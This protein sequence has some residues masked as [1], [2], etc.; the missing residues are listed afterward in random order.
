MIEKLIQWFCGYICGVLTGKQLNRFLNLCSRNGI[1]LWAISCDLER[2]V[3]VHLRLRDV[4]HLRPLLKK[5]KTRLKVVGKRG[6]PFWCHRHPYFKWFPVFCVGVF[7]LFLYSRT[8]IWNITVSGNEALSQTEIIEFLETENIT[9]GIS[10]KEIDCN[11]IE[12]ILREHYAN[13]GWVSVYVDKTNLCIQIKESLYDIYDREDA[14]INEKR[15]FDYVADKDATILSIVTRSGTALVQSGMDV[16]KGQV[17]IA[18]TY[19]VFDDS[20][21]VKEVQSVK[22]DGLIYGRTEYIIPFSLNE[23]EIVSLKISGLYDE[24]TIS[25]IANQKLHQIIS[26]FDENN[27]YIME[28]NVM[29]EDR[30][31][32]YVF[33][34]HLVCIEEIGKHV[35]VEEE[36][37]N[38]PERKDNSN[39][40]E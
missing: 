4:Y 23:M 33:Y 25:S 11:Q 20:G 12:L 16:K 26:F 18:G 31:K 14:L 30:E 40:I 22:G 29:I 19:D 34:A 36:I 13:L 21:L 9:T 7:V 3:R 32:E 28:K 1:R 24:E 38:E 37:F 15:R 17:L 27:I 5:T 35:L 6:F 10:G 39:P 8:Y 2:C